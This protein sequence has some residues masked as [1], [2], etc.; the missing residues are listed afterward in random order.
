[1]LDKSFFLRLRLLDFDDDRRVERLLLV[2]D[3]DW[4]EVGFVLDKVLN[5]PD[6][7]EKRIFFTLYKLNREKL[8]TYKH[9]FPLLQK[10]KYL[11]QFI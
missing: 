6:I 4:R 10:Y 8:N 2:T 5:V 1:M 11:I 3:T 7:K 9:Y